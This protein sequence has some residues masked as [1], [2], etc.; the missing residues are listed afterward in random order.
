MD[1]N[2]SSNGPEAKSWLGRLTQAFSGGEPKSLDELHQVLAAA[3]D[4]ELIDDDTHQ[5]L[6]GALEVSAAQVRDAMIPRG[7]MVVV[8]ANGDLK[9]VLG[10]ITDSGHSRFPV[11]RDDKDE[12]LGILLA[13]DVLKFFE[14]P[15]DLMSVVREASFIPESKR[16]NLL[17]KEFRSGRTHMAIVVDEFG[18]VA[19]LITIEDVLEEIVGDI[20]DEHDEED[21]EMISDQGNGTFTVHALTPVDEFN[22]YF[23][24][25]FSEEEF[26][27]IGGLLTG[28]LGRLP[29]MGEVHRLGDIEFEVVRADNRRLHLLSL[30]LPPR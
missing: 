19:G 29:E 1:D 30:H 4:S 28:E 11:V 24:T 26:D 9:T 14:A 20:G 7:Q 25:Q 23:G 3:R 2:S 10:I 6:E 15:F 13:K 8:P 27:T 22:E 5:M 17:L 21:D 16:L 12:V 18:G